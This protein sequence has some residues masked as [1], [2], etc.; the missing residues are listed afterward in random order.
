MGLIDEDDISSENFKTDNNTCWVISNP[1][2]WFEVIL[3][4]VFPYPIRAGTGLLN[5]YYYEDAT[6]WVDNS[7]AKDNYTAATVYKVPYLVSDA[8]L[9]VMFLRFYFIIQGLIVLSPVNRL[10]GKRICFDRGFE[11]NFAF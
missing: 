3:M 6:N 10:Y 4:V 5:P 2:F 7:G 11:P 8:L 9:A 1:W